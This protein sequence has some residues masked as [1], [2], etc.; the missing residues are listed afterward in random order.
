MDQPHRRDATANPQH[1]NARRLEGDVEVI[2]R[3]KLSKP[4]LES[5][6]RNHV[7]QGMAWRDSLFG[8]HAGCASPASHGLRD[9]SRRFARDPA[10]LL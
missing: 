6:S 8:N 7:I 9:R 4:A 10:G 2:V 3:H 5:N 1:S